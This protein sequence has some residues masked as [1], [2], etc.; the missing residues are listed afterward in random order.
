MSRTLWL[1]AFA[2][3]AVGAVSAQ[4]KAADVPEKDVV[5]TAIGAGQFKTLVTAVKEAGLVDTLK[6][7]GPFTVFAPTDEALAKVPKEKLEALLKDKKALTA[8]LTYHV[9]PGKVMAADVVKLDSAKT[10]QGESLKIVARDGKVTVNGVNVVKTDIV[11]TNGVIHVIDAVLVPTGRPSPAQERIEQVLSGAEAQGVPTR[12][13]RLKKAAAEVVELTP[14]NQLVKEALEKAVATSAAL[15]D[16]EAEKVL[17]TGLR[18]AEAILSF[19]PL[20]EAKLPEGFPEPTPVGEIHVKSYPAYRLARTSMAGKDG[21]GRAFFTLFDHIT[22][23]GIAMTAPVEM[24]FGA[25]KEKAPKGEAMAFVYEHARM[26]KAGQE[27]K[28]TVEDVPAMTALSIGLR[29]DYTLERIADV[30]ARLEAW[31]K[32]HADRYETAGPLRVLGYNSRMVP[33]DRRYAEV[34]LPVRAKPAR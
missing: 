5:D 3:G 13:A 18:E 4:V 22:R 21:E 31:L 16:E 27:G 26:G 14:A 7:T 20:M 12:V 34:Q 15:R 8:V 33:V 19:K 17:R 30:R 32:R 11:C 6:G 25:T 28:V 1:I 9:V 23:N 24:T 2:V 10:V 29:G